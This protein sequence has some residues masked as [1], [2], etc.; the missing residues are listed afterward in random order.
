MKDGG[1]TVDEEKAHKE[2]ELEDAPDFGK[3]LL[4]TV[5]GILILGG[6]TYLGYRYSQ[7]KT[8][9]LTPQTNTQAGCEQC[10]AGTQIRFEGWDQNNNGAIDSCSEA[11]KA[12]WGPSCSGSS[13]CSNPGST[14]PSSCC[15]CITSSGDFCQ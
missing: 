15:A 14:N 10:V 7:K 4:A 8:S 13:Y 5:V 2:D 3:I 12:Y 9:N 11:C 6:I 1:E